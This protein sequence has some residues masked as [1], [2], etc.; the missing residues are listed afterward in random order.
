MRIG[1]ALG[2]GGVV[3]AS[4]MIGAL[5]ALEQQTGFRPA[6]VSEVL[7]T[8]VGSLIGVMVAAAVP[9]AAM[10]AYASGVEGGVAGDP[11]DHDHDAMRLRLRLG[12]VPLPIGPGSWR[13]VLA[14]RNRTT[15]LT[16]LLPRGAARTDAISRLVERAVGSQWPAGCDLRIVACDYA[17]GERVEFARSRGPLATPA[18]AVAASCTIPA[19]YE[20]V[21]I[22]GRRNIDGGVH[23]HSNLDL[24]LD[25]ELDAVI[26]LNPMSSG[27]WIAGGGVRER[28]AG[29]RRRYSGALLD[30]EVRAL[31]A[32]GTNV[33][34]LEP[35][36]ADL[37][38]M[39]PNL[40]ARDRLAA[41]IEAGRS[42]TE[43]SLRRLGRKRLRSV[44]LAPV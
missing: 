17:S 33:L 14:P 42:S 44:G 25:A 8:S 5:E 34:V 30:A 37:A 29:V 41:V 32:R 36:F 39:G 40:M 35:A 23:S 26:A 22:G 1:L 12:R 10:A 15:L 11:D 27:A 20:P 13:M 43:R 28:L 21:V 3:G 4:W 16:G 6:E 18:E 38:A 19:V 7:G 2:A 9:T 31:R 24:L